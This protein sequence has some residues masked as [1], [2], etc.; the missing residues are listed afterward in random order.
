MSA[1]AKDV[2][3]SVLLLKRSEPHRGDFE[4]VTVLGNAEVILFF[5]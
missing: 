5:R 1:Y 2:G 3:A 4:V